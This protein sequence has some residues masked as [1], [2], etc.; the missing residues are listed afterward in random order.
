MIYLIGREK[1]WNQNPFKIGF[2]ANPASRLLSIQTGNPYRLRIVKTWEGGVEE[3]KNIHA[4]LQDFKSTGGSEWFDPIMIPRHVNIQDIVQRSRSI[5]GL[6]NRLKAS[7]RAPKPD[8]SDAP[9]IQIRLDFD[10][11]PPPST[12]APIEPDISN[13]PGTQVSLNFDQAPSPFS[14]TPT[15]RKWILHTYTCNG[16]IPKRQA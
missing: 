4:I 15:D 9:C 5:S 11:A 16:L 7:L 10:Y 14:M 6:A 2:S 8:I 3:E 13:A 1:F 12:I